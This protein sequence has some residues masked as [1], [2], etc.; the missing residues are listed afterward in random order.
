MNL[1]N[2]QKAVEEFQKAFGHPVARKPQM[3]DPARQKDRNNWLIEEANELLDAKTVVDVADAIGDVIYIA[4][5]TAVEHGIDIAHIFNIIQE[6]NMS[7]LGPDGK[8]IYK[9]DGKVAK[10]EGWQP[11][12]PKIEEELKRQANE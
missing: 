6:A 5:G 10:P 7:K 8:P 2:A 11:P 1:T 4:L 12:E 3:I 9:E